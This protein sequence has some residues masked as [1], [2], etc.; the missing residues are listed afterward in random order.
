MC[1]FVFAP[2]GSGSEHLS[3]FVKNRNLRGGLL[4]EKK[5]SFLQPLKAETM[6][7]GRSFA[8]RSLQLVLRLDWQGQ[9]VRCKA[10]RTRASRSPFRWRITVHFRA[11]PPN[12]G[13]Q[14]A[15]VR[16]SFWADDGACDAIFV[17]PK[18]NLRSPIFFKAS[19]QA[20]SDHKRAPS[21]R[22]LCASLSLIEY[23][24]MAL[25]I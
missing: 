9:L 6:P 7:F 14:T 13:C 18:C 10:K 25:L 16:L 5:K 11:E 22:L 15:I 21:A 23:F 12:F 3:H 8:N 4:V 1:L 19:C 24:F 17:K 2:L 20:L